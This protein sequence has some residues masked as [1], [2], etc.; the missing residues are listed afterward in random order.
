MPDDVDPALLER[1]VQ[2]DE[3]AFE[4]LFRQFEREVYGW[5]LRITRD[6]SAGGGC[7]GRRLLA[8]VSKPRS[9]RS[10]AELWRLDAANCDSTRRWTS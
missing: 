1:F 2:G 8:G 6:A 9:I 10:L 5:I 4:S 3:A 7:A